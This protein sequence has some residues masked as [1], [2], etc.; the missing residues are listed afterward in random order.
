VADK[1][2]F[3]GEIDPEA[4]ARLWFVDASGVRHPVEHVVDQSPNGLSWGYSGPG[5]ADTALSIL[6]RAADAATAERRAPPFMR[7]VVARF[8]VNERFTLPW[9][10][11]EAWVLAQGERL[12]G[13]ERPATADATNDGANPDPEEWSRSLA[14]RSRALDQRARRLAVAEARVDA[15]ATLVGLVP[16]VPPP[17]ISLPAEPVR[18]QL[19]ALVVDTGDDIAQLARG[20]GIE[21]DW[22]AA[23]VARQVAE[24]DLAHIAQVCEGLA[25]TPYDLWGPAGA[26]SIR[27]ATP[28]APRSGRLTPRRC[29]RSTGR[30]WPRSPPA[31]TGPGP[32]RSGCGG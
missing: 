25:C 26:R 8:G 27:L 1:R 16:N 6:T 28:M 20:R 24:V 4:G 29:P 2:A 13:R 18:R 7:E 3:I 23:V 15:M 30:T 32:V 19:D 9:A 10:Q 22:A 14:A 12:P 11:L 17:A 5:P 31:P 21:A